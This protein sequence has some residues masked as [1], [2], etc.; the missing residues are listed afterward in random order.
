[1]ETKLKLT[2]LD[3][4]CLPIF[5][6]V[7]PMIVGGHFLAVLASTHTK[8]IEFKHGIIANMPQCPYNNYH[9]AAAPPHG[10][11][12]WRNLV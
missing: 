11:T 3:S 6:Y 4:L 2:S 7:A 12:P 9:C 5:I 10:I 8:C 1:M